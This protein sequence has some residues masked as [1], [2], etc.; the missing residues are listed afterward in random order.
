MLERN[1][2]LLRGSEYEKN[3]NMCLHCGQHRK[4]S[5]GVNTRQ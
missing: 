2:Q 5:E 4:C 3:T 1:V